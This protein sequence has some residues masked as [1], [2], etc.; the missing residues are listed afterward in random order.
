MKNG[1]KSSLP[2]SMW[3]YINS[4]ALNFEEKAKMVV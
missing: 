3:Y 1:S 2:S 4:S